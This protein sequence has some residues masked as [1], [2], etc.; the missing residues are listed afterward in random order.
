MSELRKVSKTRK[1]GQPA[2]KP[3]VRKPNTVRGPSIA[4]TADDEANTP[5]ALPELAPDA[6]AQV[7]AGAL[8]RRQAF[9]QAQAQQNATPTMVQAE[10]A[11]APVP[12][13]SQTAGLVDPAI[14]SAAEKDRKRKLAL[15]TQRGQLSR[16]ILG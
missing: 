3:A 11:Q 4:N 14:A 9:M 1:Y 2:T 16:T 13:A 12:P 10:L 15:L 5:T 7:D 8:Q 6:L